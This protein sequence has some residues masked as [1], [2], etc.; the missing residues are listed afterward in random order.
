M[1]AAAGQTFTEASSPLLRAL[2]VEPY[3]EFRYT[4]QV[5]DLPIHCEVFERD[6]KAPLLVFVPG[7]STY[8]ALYSALLYHLQRRGFNVIGV[9]LRGHGHSGGERGVYTPEQVSADLRAVIDHFES[10]FTGPVSLYGYSIG[11]PLALATAESD[12]RIAA[13]LCHTLFVSEYAPDLLHLWGWH[14]LQ[15]LSFFLPHL[16][17][18]LQRLFHL[19]DLIPQ[20]R[21]HKLIAEDPL[22]VNSYPVST[23]ASVFNRRSRIMS[24]SCSFH[25]AV[26]SGEHDELVPFS[27]L[28][29]LVSKSVHPLELIAIP[30][31]NHMIPFWEPERLADIAADWLL[32]HC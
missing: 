23:L 10:R 17:L 25:A 28:E 30:G 21:F 12:E 3:L 4:E 16:H 5:G 29:R 1:K 31:G 19:Q 26:V 20:Q 2:G 32:A 15:H 13:L 27:Y 24:E 8:A 9:D 11:A 6:K 7:I 18:P 14:W 22:L